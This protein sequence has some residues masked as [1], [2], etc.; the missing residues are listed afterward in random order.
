M[1]ATDNSIMQP[2]SV[3]FVHGLQWV[4]DGFQFFR[5]NV[6]GWIVLVLTLFIIGL[7]LAFVHLIGQLLFYLLSP[8]F[9]AGVMEACRA[10]KSGEELELAHLFAGFRKNT[11]PLVTLG[12]VY[13]V[14]QIVILGVMLM[15]GG[16]AIYKVFFETADEREIEE[17]VAAMGH[18]TLPVLLG[19]GLSI[20]LMMALWFSPLLVMFHDMLPVPA[21]FTSFNACLANIAPFLLYGVILFIAALAA[22]IPFGLGLLILV[23]TLFGSIYASYLDVF[24]VEAG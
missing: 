16:D 10:Q 18:M 4:F 5:R 19:L 6:L 21:L 9:L 22:I 3:P 14:G 15:T 11:T 24:S 8:V 12:G 13:L 20:P 17:A 1:S 7:A 23:P 2:R